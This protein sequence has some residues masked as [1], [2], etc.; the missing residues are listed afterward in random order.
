MLDPDP[1]FGGFAVTPGTGVGTLN[2]TALLNVT[3]PYDMVIGFTARLHVNN[4]T[5]QE[6]TV[7]L[8]PGE[9]REI[10]M[11][12]TLLPGNHSVGINGFTRNVRV[13]R[14]ANITASDLT[15]T[16]TSGFSPLDLAAS[17]KLRNT[18]E[19]DG[20]YTATLYINGAAVDTR[21]VTVP[22]GGTSLIR[23]NHTLDTP[24]T[25]LA[26]IGALAP[27]TVRVLNEPL[28]SNL[29]VNPSSGV[30]TLLFNVT[31]MISTSEEGRGNYTVRLY[32]DGVN[33]QNKTLQ[34]TGPGAFPVFFSE[35]LS[36]P[37]N[38]AVTVNG[39]TPVTVRVLRPATFTVHSL[40]VSP[41]QG[42]L[43]LNVEVSARVSN[44]G[45]V[46]GNYTSRLY[47]DGV[48]VQSK[49]VN[50]AAGGET[51][52]TF[53]YPITQ[54]GNHT[55]TVDTLP[56]ENVNVLKP[57]TLE[58][59]SLNVTPSSAVGSANVE[60]EAEIQNT[61][62]VEGDFTVPVYLNGNLISTYTIR[63]G[64]HEG[65]VLRFQRY[66]SSPGKYTFSINNLKTAMV[67]VNPPKRTYRFTF[68]NTGSYTTTV[69]YYVTVYSSAGKKLAY[70]TYKFTLKR[71]GSYTATIGYY[72]YDAK[73][74][75]TRKI[76]NPSRYTRTIRLS[77][78]FRADTLSAT[79]SH[80]NTIRGY[81][82]VYIT[83]TFRVV[84]MRITVT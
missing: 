23:F 2:V 41:H 52:V 3:N 76:Y 29:S 54:R 37:G 69:T 31:A 34:L 38:H 30:S 19:V 64:P 10:S 24:G 12:T 56:A 74:V 80:T 49:T 50:V 22:A 67:Y 84:D 11:K 78:T 33:V 60:V 42:V 75:T 71:G 5:V 14:P 46:P 9:T 79:L 40:M 27:V 82:Y 18:G 28:I 47:I 83:R 53:T 35:K 63:V 4:Q 26:G 66:I 8:N 7:S 43:P 65:A 39:L 51:P 61:G 58:I 70:K 17:A 15:V 13:F 72:P 55:F 48:P 44:V 77:E 6:N 59:G 20:E 16:P 36:D 1:V 21:T 68:K 81:R 32:I 62:D 25:Y 73:I 57:A 45:D